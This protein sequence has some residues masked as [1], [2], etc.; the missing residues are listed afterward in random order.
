M[1]WEAALPPA[2]APALRCGMDSSMRA[3]RRRVGPR[4]GTAAAS[5]AGA[6]AV[7]VSAAWPAGAASG[8]SVGQ[9]EQLHHI[10]LLPAGNTLRPCL[11]Q[12]GADYRPA[13]AQRVAQPRTNRSNEPLREPCKLR[14]GGN[15]A[16]PRK[17]Q[18]TRSREKDGGSAPSRGGVAGAGVDSAAAALLAAGDACSAAAAAS[19][20]CAPF[21]W[22]STR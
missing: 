6:A 3:W 22:F 11:T 2:R 8:D 13:V 4:C 17:Q 9:Q 20:S 10:G 19:S 14:Q 15:T 12:R 16:T 7:V 1:V 21:R 18:S 5:S